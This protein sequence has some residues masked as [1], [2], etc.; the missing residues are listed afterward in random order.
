MNTS[1]Y[2]TVVCSFNE[3]KL[4][5]RT[6]QIEVSN[7]WNLKTSIVPI[8]IGALGTIPQTQLSNINALNCN[9]ISLHNI[10]D[11]ALCESNNMYILRKTINRTEL[12]TYKRYGACPEDSAWILVLFESKIDNIFKVHVWP[13]FE[14]LKWDCMFFISY[15]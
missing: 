6:L 3:K 7:M 10:Q 8:I 13:L 12:C 14:K 2:T 4:K 9:L 11:I 5:Y 15:S 1:K